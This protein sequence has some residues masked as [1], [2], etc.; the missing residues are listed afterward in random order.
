MSFVSLASRRRAELLAVIAALIFIPLLYLHQSWIPEAAVS[1]LYPI[2]GED[3]AHGPDGNSSPLFAPELACRHLPGAEDVLV[4]LKTGSTVSHKKLPIHFNTT[5]RCIPHWIVFSDLEEDVAG[6]HVHDVL[7]EIDDSVKNTAAEFHLYHQIQEWH[8]EEITPTAINETLRKQAWDLDK[9]K[10]LPLVKKALRTRPE[11]KWYFFMEA[12]SFLMW[13]NLLLYLSQLNTDESLYL[14]AQA[15]ISDTEFAH[16]GSGFVISNRALRTVVEEYTARVS[17][18]NE[19]TRNEWAG[20]GVLAKAMKNRGIHLTRAFP[21]VQGETPYTLDYTERHCCYPVVSYH[22]MSP[23]WIQTMWDYE[24]EWLA[25]EKANT[26]T[27]D[28][29]LSEPIRHRH[30]FAHFVQSTISS[31]EKTAWDNLSPDLSADGETT[32]EMC[33]D[34]CKA[35]DSCV[36]WL[37]TAPGDCKIANV[38]RLGSRPT[39][40]DAVKY[41]SGW[42]ADR[43]AAFVDK[44]GL[45]RS[46][47]IMPNAGAV[48]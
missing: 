32:L 38:V 35:A 13:S 18:Y 16:G 7:D 22:H 28:S 30:V 8:A 29:S 46:D 24:Q 47:W 48:A 33:R 23:E 9:W 4:I 1:H 15:W 31:G 42:M 39:D 34:I 12:D 5:F 17:Y 43:V 44:M 41:T 10:F 20:D 27:L 2:P 25:K 3:L 40:E 26:T 36:Q 19:L 14:G 45:C 11:A 6:H 37:F 21:I